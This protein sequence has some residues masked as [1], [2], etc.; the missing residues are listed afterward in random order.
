MEIGV[1]YKIKH[2]RK[3]KFNIRVSDIDNEW[4]TGVVV[5]SM[6]GALLKYNEVYSG[7]SITIRKCHFTY[8]PFNQSSDC[9]NN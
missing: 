4:V 9:I 2:E 3:G 5:D 7:E 6:A 1:L 8:E